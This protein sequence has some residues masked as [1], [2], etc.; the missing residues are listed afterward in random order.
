MIG[1]AV[2]TVLERTTVACAIVLLVAGQSA[3]QTTPNLR[4]STRVETYVDSDRTL[5]VRP[6]VS[7]D[8]R[9]NESFR[10]GASYTVDAISSASIDVVT[11]ASQRIREVRHDASATLTH[12]GAEDR[13]TSYGY[14]VGYEPDYLANAASVTHARNLDESRLTYLTVRASFA[15]GRVGTVADPSF[16]RRVF[17]TSS[18]VS[19]SR[20]LDVD[21]IL[22]TSL[23]FSAVNGFQSSAYRTVRMG[24]WTAYRYTGTDPA[25]SE[26]VFVGVTQSA[27]EHHPDARYRARVSVEFIQAILR[28]AAVDVTLAA[29]RDSWAMTA[30]ELA[31][32]LRWE[33]KPMWLF[34]MGG[35]AYLQSATW[36]WRRRYLNT[37]DTRGFLTDDKE[38]GPMRSYTVHGTMEIPLRSFRIT[39]RVELDLYRYPE[40]TLLPE[41][42]ALVTTLGLTYQR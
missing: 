8:A 4:A 14:A 15:Y 25:A 29:Y 33:P 11:R 31:A 20:V 17:T 7:L 37:T 22:R 24:D 23:E 19:L 3:A 16:E 6:R 38:L 2:R 21:R 28:R 34:R 40:F 13:R 1:T 5:V 36:F 41:K 12:V 27:R 42:R 39:A 10:L 32:E 35:R 26:W 30:G 9:A 18:S